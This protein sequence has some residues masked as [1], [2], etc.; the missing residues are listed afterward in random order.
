MLQHVLIQEF[1]KH[2]N[3]DSLVTLVQL[4]VPEL[5]LNHVIRVLPLPL[6]HASQDI[7]QKLTQLVQLLV[8]QFSQEILRDVIKQ[9]EQLLQNAKLVSL[10]LVVLQLVQELMSQI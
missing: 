6:I 3:R 1:L 7:G 4:L 2:V 8:H 9:L 5:M 10:K